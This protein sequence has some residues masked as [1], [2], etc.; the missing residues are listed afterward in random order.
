MASPNDEI[1]KSSGTIKPIIKPDAPTN[2]VMIINKPSFSMPKRLNSP[3][4]LGDMK[5]DAV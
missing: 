4:I 3:F 5:Y 2:W 1:I